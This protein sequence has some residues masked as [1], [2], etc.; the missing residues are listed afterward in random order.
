M[1]HLHFDSIGGASGDMIL[2][3]LLDLGVSREDLQHQLTGLP[4][5]PFEIEV[6]SISDRGLHGTR[7]NVH[8]PSHEHTHGSADHSQPQ[9]H[10][11]HRGLIEIRALIDGS[12]LSASVKA[13][14]LRVFRRLAEAEAHV[15]GTTPDQVHFHEVG[16]VD[17]IIDIVGAC[18]GLERLGVAGV[19]VGPLP[20][21]HGTV[22]CAHGILPVPAPATVELLKG[23]T[24]APTDEPFELVTPT[25]AALLTTCKTLETFPPGSRILKVGQ[26]FGHRTLNGRPNVLR[27]ML[28]ESDSVAADADGCPATDTCLVL[29][30]NLDDL[31]PELT[32]SLMKR[33]LDAGALDVFLTPV[34]MKKQ[35]P[36]ILLTVLCRPEQRPTMLD[37]I[38][39]ESTTFGIREY[40]VQRTVLERRHESVETPFGRVRVK[41]GRWQGSDITVS[42]EYEDCRRAAESA[43]V[44]VRAVYEAALIR[45]VECGRKKS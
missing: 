34:Q 10:P 27:A 26:G 39:R 33:L 1:K 45:N 22:V 44:S 14:S 31:T 7:V 11:P 20:L 28:M 3:A 13:A 2:A 40:P 25:G 17:A 19:S 9:V 32:G 16:A 4:I 43:G 12:Q 6:N 30:C 21:G 24:V 42:P 15:H 23:F 35:R 38:F 8:V 5:G 36:G 29:E 18:L 41:I 37:L